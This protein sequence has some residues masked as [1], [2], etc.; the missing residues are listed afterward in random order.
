MFHPKTSGSAAGTTGFTVNGVD[1]NQLFEPASSSSQRTGATNFTVNGT[2][3][4]DVF[5]PLGKAGQ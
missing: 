5:C 4:K 3:L 1:L 2:D